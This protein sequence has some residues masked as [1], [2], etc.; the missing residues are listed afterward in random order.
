MKN[1]GFKT[2]CLVK[3]ASIDDESRWL[4]HN[5]LDIL[6]GAKNYEC[7]S[8]AIDDQ[9]F[10]VAVA[11]RT[12]KKRGMVLP[13]DQ[14][15]QKVYDMAS[16]N[17]VAL[18]FG[19]EDRGLYNKEVNE[20]GLLLTIPAQK[21]HP[22]LNLSHA[23][24]VVAYELSRVQYRKEPV[25]D[26]SLRAI[27]R[28]GGHVSHGELAALYE[29][30][31]NIITMLDYMPRGDRNIEKRIIDD[32]KHFIGRAGLTYWELKMLHGLCSQIEI[33]VGRRGEVM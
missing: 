2:L 10:V 26:A 6:E 5:A 23:V 24:M 27:N 7:L 21:E 13:L 20:C 3:P 32:L 30:M 8:D 22:S 28:Q 29:R 18:L 14:G 31:A 4:A 33:K 25:Q 16:D 15:A 17:R 1:M 9:S 19:R 11:R 12:G